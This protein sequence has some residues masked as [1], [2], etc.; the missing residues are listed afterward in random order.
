MQNPR[1]DLTATTQRV[2]FNRDDPIMQKLIENH[3]SND[4]VDSLLRDE[5]TLDEVTDEAI[6]AWL[7]AIQQTSTTSKLP[8]IEGAISV[9]EFQQA[10]KAVKERTSS[11]S[12]GLHYSI[13]KVVAREDDLA[14][15][16]SIMTSLPFMYGFV[17]KR[18]ATIVDVM[19]EKKKDV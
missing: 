13:W 3:G 8:K 18:W 6:Q 14:E 19:I 1:D 4:L 17:N 7:S 16:L 12:S 11:S 15:W 9:A 10:F 5:M 2:L